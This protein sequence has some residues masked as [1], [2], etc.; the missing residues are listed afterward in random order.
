MI[1]V[2]FEEATQKSYLQLI[3]DASKS[4]TAVIVNQSKASAG[5][6]SYEQ[7]CNSAEPN[8]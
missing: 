1:T 2:F 6:P 8:I 5:F 4:K 7:Q 3:I